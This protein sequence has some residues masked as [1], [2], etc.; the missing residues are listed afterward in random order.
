MPSG[1]VALLSGRASAGVA[2]RYLCQHRSPWYAQE[3]R[4][5]APFVC[6]YLGRED[7]KSGRPFRFI[8]NQSNATIT[9]VYLAL[10]PKEPL[11]QAIARIRLSRVMF[12]KSSTGFA[13]NPCWQKAAFMAEGCTSWNRKSWRMF[14]QPSLPDGYPKRPKTKPGASSRLDYSSFRRFPP[15]HFLEGEPGERRARC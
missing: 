5:A 9:N 12:G 10:Y 7:V 11:A 6:T 14:R 4:P 13:R 2:D 8:L 1:F 3:N 15:T